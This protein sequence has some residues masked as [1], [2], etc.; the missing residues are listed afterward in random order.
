MTC[1]GRQL[2]SGKEISC[3]FVVAGGDRSKV[4]ASVEEALDEIAFAVEHV[5]ACAR[6]GVAGRANVSRSSG[7]W[8]HDD[9]VF[10][11]ERDVGATYRADRY[12]GEEA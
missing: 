5:V 8:E 1:G 3:Q 7:A 4:F 12:G 10:D 2:N 6:I 9:D 11:G